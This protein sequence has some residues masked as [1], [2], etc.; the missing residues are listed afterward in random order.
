M[1]YGDFELLVVSHPDRENVY[2]E[3]SFG[4]DEMFHVFFDETG[5]VELGELVVELYP[6]PRGTSWSLLPHADLLHVLKH[7]AEALLGKSQPLPECA[8]QP[9]QCWWRDEPFPQGKPQKT[10]Q[11]GVV[12]WIAA[13]HADPGRT[14]RVEASVRPVGKM[15]ALWRDQ[16]LGDVMVDIFPAPGDAIWVLR[17]KD[18]TW[19]LHEA[20]RTLEIQMIRG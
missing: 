11:N 18:L 3:A 5:E 8:A 14:L 13:T 15:F 7:A 1:I 10:E 9:I 17:H 19:L 2:V 16:Q 20:Q 12:E 6:P 4:P